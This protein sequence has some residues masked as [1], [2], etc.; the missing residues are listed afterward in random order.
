MVII[1]YRG[2]FL[3]ISSNMPSIR[4]SNGATRRI[5]LWDEENLM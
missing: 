3:A 1:A 4:L 5:Y 2:Y